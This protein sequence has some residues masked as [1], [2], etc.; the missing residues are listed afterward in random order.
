MDREHTKWFLLGLLVVI[1]TG[2]VAVQ[3]KPKSSKAISRIDTIDSGFEEESP[4]IE[5]S[6]ISED[7]GP[8]I[9]IGGEP[10]REGDIIDGF[11]FVEPHP[12][13]VNFERND[14]TVVGNIN[15]T[16]TF[17]SS[18]S[19]DLL[20]QPVN[21]EQIRYKNSNDYCKQ[22]KPPPYNKLLV[23]EIAGTNQWEMFEITTIK[24]RVRHINRGTFFR[25]ASGNIY[26]V[27]ELVFLSEFK[28][29][30]DIMC[31][32]VI[33]LT[34]GR[35]Y[36]LIIEGVEVP[37]LCKKLNRE[38]CNISYGDNIIKSTIINDFNGLEFENIFKLSNG[39]IWE[40]TEFYSY[41]NVTLM[42]KVIIWWSGSVYKMKVEGIEKAVT[43]QQ[44][45]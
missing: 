20:Q 44:V 38:R 19:N 12:D 5:A 27:A 15:D 40:Q 24:D 41:I 1:H 9:S 18:K 16:D 37:L 31:P 10:F 26:E 25:T 45:Q 35:L 3:V 6:L 22:Y 21:S 29:R 8:F 14:K 11:R 30:S 7:S 23:S 36:E 13:K 4:R 17:T 39:Q 43:V 2:I 32:D 28:T 42:P 34:D 33:V